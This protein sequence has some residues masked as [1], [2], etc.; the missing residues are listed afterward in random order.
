[1]RDH[2]CETRTRGEAAGVEL[3]VESVGSG[4]LD[5]RE[6]ATMPACRDVD[7]LVVGSGLAG[8]SFAAL[9]ARSGARVRVLESH[10][11]AGGYA[12]T[13]EF[14]KRDKTYRFNAQLHYV[15]NCGEGRTVN[16]FLRRLGLDGDVT[17]ESY[18][19]DGFDR[20]WMP[21]HTL[22]IP[23]D[24]ALLIER[25]A[26]QFPSHRAALTRFVQEVAAFAEDL[27]NL[28]TLA[29]PLTAVTRAPHLIRLARYRK[30][31]LQAVFDEFG[32]PLPAQTLLAL[33]WPDFMLPP[34]QL[35]FIAWVMLFSG[36]VRGAYYATHHFQHV[37]D[38]M[39]RVIEAAGGEVLLNR[40]VTSFELDDRRVRGVGVEVVDDDGAATGEREEHLVE[41][42]V[43]NMDPKRAAQMIGSEHFSR[44]VRRQLEYDYS[45]SN[46][47][48]YAVVDGLDLREHGFGKSNLF[49]TEDPDLNQCFRRMRD[50]GDYSRPSFAV[51]VPTLLTE[52]ARDCPPDMQVLELLTVAD[53]ERFRHLKFSNARAYRRA[54]NAVEDRLLELLEER[55][56]PGLRE[57]LCFRTSGTPTTNQRYCES[58][59]GNSYGSALTP[60]NMGLD[61]LTQET[62]LERFYFCNASSGY[63][64]FAG[65]IWTGCRLYER[66]TGDRILTG[67][68]PDP[69]R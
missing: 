59:M 64:G 35:S 56:V 13:F 33:Q 26:E 32:L 1:M 49:H 14:G 19:P 43:C 53:Y 54:K 69:L 65:T 6:D 57:H 9:M 48:V 30:A 22:R 58:P 24:Y 52:A 45:A 40:R 63:P 23:G 60:N 42:V 62:S 16:R 38:S 31:T 8:L 34:D 66:L 25:L 55:H 4:R 27:D 68:L 39:V 3:T 67:P 21:G 29:Q 11:V 17:F 47:M 12:H 37:V 15:W 2:Y 28:P 61:R 20:M 41:H 18:D 36:Y 46:L 5:A 10:T 44:R 50:G 7:V 51:T